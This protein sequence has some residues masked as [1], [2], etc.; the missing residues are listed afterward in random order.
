MYCGGERRD[1]EHV[2]AINTTVANRIDIPCQSGRTPRPGTTVRG[3]VSAEDFIDRW[4][5]PDGMRPHAGHPIS[6]NDEEA[7]RIEFGGPPA[8]LD[9]PGQ[10]TGKRRTPLG[11]EKALPFVGMPDYLA[12]ELKQGVLC[13]EDLALLFVLHRRAKHV[14]HTPYRSTPPI[15]LAY[16]TEN[17]RW[18]GKSESLRHRL[19]LLRKRGYFDYEALGSSRTGYLYRF[20]LRFAPRVEHASAAGNELKQRTRC[21][22]ARAVGGSDSPSAERPAKATAKRPRS[23]D[24]PDSASSGLSP[25]GLHSHV[26]PSAPRTAIPP[27]APVTLASADPSAVLPQVMPESGTRRLASHP[28]VA[29]TSEEAQRT[30]ESLHSPSFSED[31]R[32]RASLQE[33]MAKA[34]A[35]LKQRSSEVDMGDASTDLLFATEAAASEHHA[36]RPHA[37]TESELEWR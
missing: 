35:A 37:A 17:V 13:K 20:H 10:H 27:S 7:E 3:E 23:E 26:R 14:L 8:H 11:R 21:R 2:V 30:E 28:P 25:D 5:D 4:D 9:G 1:L 31:Q 36:A 19:G 15:S 34:G 6:G 29:E 12:D 24:T 32:T 16:I 33:A 18:S 22:S